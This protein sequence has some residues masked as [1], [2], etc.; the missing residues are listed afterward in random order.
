MSRARRRPVH[1]STR[2]REI[3]VAAQA[4]GAR[5]RL[6]PHSGI[7]LPPAE[8]D[9]PVPRRRDSFLVLHGGWLPTRWTPP[10]DTAILDD[11]PATVA[12]AFTR[13]AGSAARSRRDDTS[14]AVPAPEPRAGTH[15]RHP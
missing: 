7:G 2:V 14:V 13:D 1:D 15:E 9:R 5:A 8:A 12:A 6:A 4:V 11:D 3:R 10:D